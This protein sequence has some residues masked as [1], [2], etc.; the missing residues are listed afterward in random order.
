[1]KK[2]GKYLLERQLA[3]GGMAEVFLA[4]QHGPAGFEKTLVIKRILPHFANNEQFITMFLDEARTSA[5]LN[6][7]NLVQIYELGEIEGSYYIA[8][9]Y[10]QGQSLS[11]V[12]SRL[13]ELDI[14]MPLHI[15]AKIIASTCAGLDYAHS[16]LGVDGAPLN[17]V[18]RDISPDNVLVS[19]DGAVKM[20]DFGIAKARTSETKTQAGTVKG[21]FCY[22]SPEQVTGKR[23]DRRSDL[24]S[25]GI[26]LYEL[27]TLRKPFG[28]GA[29]L[30]T[31]TAIVNDPPTHVNEAV[32]GYPLPLWQII[33]QALDKGRETRYSTAHEMQTDLERFIHRQGEFISDRDI[34]SYIRKLFSGKSDDI[35]VLRGM[36]SGIRN[37]TTVAS[38]SPTA[39]TILNSEP[40]QTGEDD[41]REEIENIRSQQ[42]VAASEQLAPVNHEKTN[43]ESTASGRSSVFKTALMLLLVAGLGVGA[44]FGWDALQKTGV[45]DTD[46]ETTVST[47][48]SDPE[49]NTGGAERE[50]TEPKPDVSTAPPPVTEDTTVTNEEKDTEFVALVEDADTPPLEADAAGSPT[51]EEET[52][53]MTPEEETDSTTPEEETDSTAGPPQADGETALNAGDTLEPNDAEQVSADT[54]TDAPETEHSDT[55]ASA[56][57][58]DSADDAG[59]TANESAPDGTETQPPEQI[60]E[61]ALETE[62]DGDVTDVSQEGTDPDT[63]AEQTAKDDA[64]PSDSTQP[65][66]ADTSSAEDE[67]DSE[68]LPGDE[69]VRENPDHEETTA[70]L[71][72]DV[73][74]PVPETEA[75]PTQIRITAVVRVQVRID[76][77]VRGH[78]PITVDV[79]PGRHRV[80]A[81]GGGINRN[82]TVRIEEGEEKRIH[83]NRPTQ[84]GTIRFA[85]PRGTGIRIGGRDLGTAPVPP[86]RVSLGKHRITLIDRDNPN[87]RVRR[88]VTITPTD[89]N[90]TVRF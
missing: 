12:I 84:R 47:S 44:W 7:P 75:S 19:L 58:S 57:P 88:R 41:A 74:A 52:D 39:A 11:K 31:V 42:T 89:L 8:M 9:E 5:K 90:A 37:L 73:T 64:G 85:V 25:L 1:M 46:A 10:I 63:S 59:S 80:H 40:P 79:T 16:F 15:A 2:Y 76:G 22:M 17:L 29:D 27:T 20:I 49:S 50:P 24:F 65:V 38:V 87:R 70:P 51:S 34:G 72:E 28:D 53:S 82:Y 83:V 26:V 13:Q 32:E 35:E 43:L 62:L 69:E 18:H 33:E 56:A 71:V 66:V 4:R 54:T 67:Q 81:Q 21:K 3:I 86:Q 60:E 23:L 77:E 14:F 45:S 30:M 36:Q 48:P 55:A 78:T 61:D 6:H 68:P